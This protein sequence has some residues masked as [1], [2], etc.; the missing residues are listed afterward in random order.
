MKYLSAGTFGMSDK[1]I[2][3]ILSCNLERCSP[4]GL[5]TILYPARGIFQVITRFSGPFCCKYFITD[6]F[7]RFL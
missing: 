3:K 7:S 1:V 6:S 2:G 4:I 5:D